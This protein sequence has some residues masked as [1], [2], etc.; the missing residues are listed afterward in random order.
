MEMLASWGRNTKRMD[1][2]TVGKLLRLQRGTIKVRV[3]RRKPNLIFKEQLDRAHR[4]RD[5]RPLS[6]CAK[7]KYM[8]AVSKTVSWASDPSS[9]G[10]AT[11]GSVPRRCEKRAGIVCRHAARR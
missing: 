3:F 7:R 8:S 5:G 6:L 10:T 9:N 4:L 1:A 11:G 2:A